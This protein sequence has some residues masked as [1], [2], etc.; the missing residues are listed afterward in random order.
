MASVETFVLRAMGTEE[1]QPLEVIVHHRGLQ[2]AICKKAPGKACGDH[3][4]ID[5]LEAPPAVRS[6]ALWSI[7]LP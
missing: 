1:R 6:I 4:K 5:M 3:S 2:N 7:Q